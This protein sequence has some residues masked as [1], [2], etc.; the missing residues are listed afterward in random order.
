[1][2]DTKKTAVILLSAF[3]VIIITMAALIPVEKKQQIYEKWGKIAVLAETDSRAKY[4]IENE[5]LYPDEI[6]KLLRSDPEE[7]LN[8]VYNYVFH[9]DDYMTMSYTAEELD[10]RVPEL[11]MDD[12]RWSYQRFNGEFF[13]KDSGCEAVALTM[14]YIGLTGKSDLDPYQIILIADKMDAIGV[15]GGISSNYT[16]DLIRAVGLDAVEYSFV[17]DNRQKDSSADIGTMKSIL[18]SGH[19]IIAGMVGDTFGTHAIIIRGYEGD[20]F[21]INDPEDEENSARLWSYEEL[22]PELYYMWD[23]YA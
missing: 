10:G 4:I 21:Y 15:F 6:I 22:E 11:Y 1:M 18:D 7:E 13:I 3:A 12:P 17:D 2:S 19:V 9:K 5:Q 23:V 20:S 16:M 14:A 8:Y